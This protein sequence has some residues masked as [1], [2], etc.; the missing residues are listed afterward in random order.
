MY[1]KAQQIL[2][3]AKL[4]LTCRKPVKIYKHCLDCRAERSKGNLERKVSAKAR[5]G[6][7]QDGRNENRMDE[8]PTA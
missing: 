3:D 8:L 5:E 1:S 7:T 6:A 4:C 2:I